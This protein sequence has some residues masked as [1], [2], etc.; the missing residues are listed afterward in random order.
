[1][2][3]FLSPSKP[4]ISCGFGRGRLARTALGV[5]PVL[6][7]QRGGGI[8]GEEG[9]QVLWT[10]LPS[11]HSDRLRA[12][13]GSTVL[14]LVSP[15]A[16]CTFW[17]T[18]LAWM[19]LGAWLVGES[20]QPCDRLHVKQRA[21]ERQPCSQPPAPTTCAPGS[22]PVLAWGR[23]CAKRR[24]RSWVFAPAVLQPFP[25]C[26]HQSFVSVELLA[27]LDVGFGLVFA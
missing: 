13:A 14:I 23:L 15:L 5:L 22:P 24:D 6:P 3:P 11:P 2:L 4:P 25:R 27:E 26:V 1:M 12:L 21:G 16:E 10:P 9:R 8:S 20:H 7:G 18:V 19:G 17:P